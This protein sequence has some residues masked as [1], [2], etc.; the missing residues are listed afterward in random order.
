MSFSRVRHEL[1][2]VTVDAIALAARFRA[3]V[4]DVAEVDAGTGAADFDPAHA[5]GG[6][7][8]LGQRTGFGTFLPAR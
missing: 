7:H 3:V 1:Q 2:H 6:I 5:V 8:M 4:E